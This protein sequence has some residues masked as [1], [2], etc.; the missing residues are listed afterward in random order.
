M[1]SGSS[2]ND[3]SVEFVLPGD[4]GTLTG[5]YIY[6]RR[7]VDGLRDRGWSVGVHSLDASFPQPTP[8]ALAQAERVLAGL[9]AAG[10]VVIDGLALGGLAEILEQ[11]SERLRLVALVHHP[12][13]LETGL[14]EPTAQQLFRAERAS[15]QYFQTVVVTSHWTAAALAEYGVGA[16]RITVVE[17][18]TTR[19]LARSGPAAVPHRLLCVASLTPRKGHRVLLEALAKLE[20][21]A[22][23]LDC[24][25][26]LSMDPDCA[27]EIR[28]RIEALGLGARVRLLGELE[29][30]ALAAVYAQADTFVLASYMEGYGMALMEAV[31]AGLPVVSTL[32][33]AI[34]HVVPTT[35]RRLVPAGDSDALA[36]SLDALVDGGATWQQLAAAAAAASLPSWDDA[37]DGF[38]TLLK[39]AAAA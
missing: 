13:A 14:D 6:D 28:A 32:A 8:A 31:A 15:L 39:R 5:G 34:P 21:Q 23:Q 18:G 36:D 37:V 10:Q 17:P 12:L 27:T 24:A 35:A 19:S 2:S 25:G 11:T 38:E 33:G 3:R 26:S 16:E 9:P 29:P 22:W 7:L 30:E 1:I 4:L 20:N